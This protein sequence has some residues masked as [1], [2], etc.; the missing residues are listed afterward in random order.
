MLEEY[1]RSLS[2]N[3]SVWAPAVQMYES[4]HWVGH[5]VATGKGLAH[6]REIQMCLWH[7]VNLPLFLAGSTSCICS[8]ALSAKQNSRQSTTW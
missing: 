1:D 2:D 4:V 5:S 6:L 7:T 8:V 3:P